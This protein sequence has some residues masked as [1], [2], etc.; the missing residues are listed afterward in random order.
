MKELTETPINTLVRYLVPIKL[1][2]DEDK[3]YARR[4]V[5]RIIN[6]LNDDDRRKVYK[7]VE[8]PERKNRPEWQKLLAKMRLTEAYQDLRFL[9]IET[10]ERLATI[11]NLIKIVEALP[12]PNLSI[13]I[14][15]SGL[16]KNEPISRQSI[17]SIM[18]DYTKK[19]NLSDDAAEIL[20]RLSEVME[21]SHASIHE[22][23]VIPKDIEEEMN[24]Y[25]KVA[26]EDLNLNVR[27]FNALKRAGINTLE[28]VI[29]AYIEGRLDRVR[30]AGATSRSYKEIIDKITEVC[31]EQFIE[32]AKDCWWI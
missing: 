16:D 1:K 6:Q 21:V 14:S 5:Q 11:K 18:E 24:R 15:A 17:R 12:N 25:R 26:I 27:A 10:G 28:D 7:Y 3:F 2:T 23:E 31:G 19:N 4:V 8:K 29:R 22:S 30:N 9:A 13:H 32:K 20:A